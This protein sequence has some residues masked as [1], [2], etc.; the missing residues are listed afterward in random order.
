MKDESEVTS[1]EPATWSK[2]THSVPRAASDPETVL[3]EFLRCFL[4]DRDSG[5]QRSLDDYCASFPGHSE[6]I[7]REFASLLSAEE[8]RDAEHAAHSQGAPGRRFGPYVLERFIG[9]GGQ[10]LVWLARDTRLDRPVA[11]KLLTEFASFSPAALERFRREAQLASRLHDPGIC[12]VYETGSEHGVHFIAMRYVE[13]KSLATLLDEARGL[14]AAGRPSFPALPEGSATDDKEM[15]AEVGSHARPVQHSSTEPMN[16]AEHVR[17]AVRLIER[18]AR[19]LQLAHEAY[20]VHRDIKPGNVMVTKS[21]HP[22]LLDFGLAGVLDESLPNCTRTGDVF[23]TPAYMAPEQLSPADLH[24][25]AQ[26]DRR[27]DIY[28][29]GATLYECVTLR[30]PFESVTRETLYQAIRTQPPVDP[31]RMNPAIAADLWT[32]LQTC[33]AKEPDRRYVTAIALAEDLRRF[34]EGEPVRAHPPSRSYKALRFVQRY[35]VL[36]STALVVT[37][38]LVSATAVATT[39]YFQARRAEGRATL[40]TLSESRLRIQAQDSAAE[41]TE[42]SK[43]ARESALAA[44]RIAY[45]SQMQLAFRAWD[46]RN[47]ARV[48][49]LLESQRP[50]L[51]EQDLRGFEWY[52]L[53]KLCH[54]GLLAVH[55]DPEAS[56]C[57]AFTAAADGTSFLS[58]DDHGRAT[59]RRMSD[60]EILSVAD[61]ACF[62]ALFG[63][64]FSRDSRRLA[65]FDGER[66]QPAVEVWD[67]GGWRR[68]LYLEQP[69]REITQVTLSRDGRF[70]A[71]IEDGAKLVIVDVE[72]GEQVLNQPAGIGVGRCMTFSPDA[73]LLAIGGTDPPK[74]ASLRI[75]A[76]GTGREKGRAEFPGQLQALDFSPDGRRLAASGTDW[77]VHI[78]DAEDA[79]EVMRLEGHSGGIC[80]LRFSPDGGALATIGASDDT[81]RFW[82]VEKGKECFAQRAQAGVD[83]GEL[84][85]SPDGE[86]VL[87]S[88]RLGG[89]VRI[90]SLAAE[91]LP[92]TLEA[93]LDIPHDFIFSHSLLAFAPNS[94]TLA[95][96]DR[97]G[98]LALLDVASRARRATLAVGEHVTCA[99]FSSDG[100]ALVL[101][102]QAG[103][104]E[105]WDVG[106]AKRLARVAAHA[107]QV[108][109][110]ALS[111]DGRTVVSGGKDGKVALWDVHTQAGKGS[112]SQHGREVLCVL[113]DQDGTSVLSSGRD[114]TVQRWNSDSLEQPKVTVG[115]AF[116]ELV[117]PPNGAEVATVE[118][119]WVPEL[120]GPSLSEVRRR[121]EGHAGG[122][123]RAI[124]FAA[125]GRT[126]AT[127]SVDKSVKLWH[128]ETGQEVCTLKFA[129]HVHSVAFSPDGLMLATWSCD[130]I[131]KLWPAATPDAVERVSAV[132]RPAGPNCDGSLEL[133]S[134]WQAKGG[135]KHAGFGS[136]VASAGDVDGDGFEDVLVGASQWIHERAEVGAAF[137]FRGCARGLSSSSPSWT[138]KGETKAGG[139]GAALA[140]AGDVNGDGFDDVIIGA[141][142]GQG[143]AAGRASLYLGSASGLASAPAWTATG[144]QASARFGESV[145]CAGDVNGDGFDDV[146]VGA[147]G[148]DG[149]L[150][151]S[152]RAFLYLGS[153]HG[154]SEKAD[155]TARGAQ[156][157]AHFGYAVS[158]AGDVN[159]DGYDDVLIGAYGYDGSWVNEGKVDLYL[160][161]AAGL[162]R[163]PAWTR[164]GG[165]PQ[166]ALGFSVSAAGDVNGDGYDDLLIGALYYSHSLP[167]EGKAF[168]FLGAPDGI[169]IAGDWSPEGGQ[170]GAYFGHCVSTAGDVNGD[171]FDDVLVGAS[172]FDSTKIDG[173]AA[174]LYLGSAG[175]LSRTACWTAG[176]ALEGAGFGRSLAGAGDVDGDGL[177]DFLVGSYMYGDD[178]PEGGGHA[179]LYCGRPTKPGAR[180]P[181][182]R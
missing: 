91:P 127:G 98:A 82:E 88:A 46:D 141:S 121:F 59:R 135:Q 107:G 151:A 172:G 43:L 61:L 35:R 100:E 128:V 162:A 16:A 1:N 20:V 160:G 39:G 142:N 73:T 4:E 108:N 7:A 169:P 76:V 117:R 148:G 33:L 68:V 87:V 55:R 155:W 104:L 11:L 78:L 81:L 47:L 163:E 96:N 95:M 137:L 26:V 99:I 77:T 89:A 150:I 14:S 126:L 105:W 84:S 23:G 159:G 62:P 58:L 83:C 103:D 80:A 164:T 109:D 27:A 65:C 177:C 18:L 114:N 179:V 138:A 173:G 115:T 146:L 74:A 106:Q 125:D 12:T 158:T 32:I 178:Q 41:A 63:A 112:H 111:P 48:L 2:Q 92:I 167:F 143:L 10:G 110:L 50:R 132:E 168:L 165:Q 17:R 119:N 72:Q 37:A 152:G 144:D 24:S 93:P 180:S 134:P 147:H 42:Q 130:G 140:G 28:A 166:G 175:G 170:A 60:G 54:P 79:S 174:W 86:R 124:A 34:L 64:S 153:A 69:S 116:F 129:N 145:A 120:R 56:R 70:V 136:P 157:N 101:G 102:T 45:A 75:I 31:R 25:G 131:L 49:G 8:D 122:S 67:T 176:G 90:W 36:V 29:L 113:F 133:A 3:N 40:A 156:A 97:S 85:F 44:R 5:R 161:S 15:V 71:W 51:L 154:L 53:W 171:G 13:G 57:V 22:V 149:E 52:C 94:R 182:D 66:T 6:L 38:A 30:H 123:Y 9:R 19:S 181:T 21:G 139:F 118:N